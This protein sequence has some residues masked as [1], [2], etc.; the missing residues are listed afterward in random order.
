MHVC[1]WTVS[2]YPMV[3][4]WLRWILIGCGAAYALLFRVA[5]C[6]HVVHA[7]RVHARRAALVKVLIVQAVVRVHRISTYYVDVWCT[8]LTL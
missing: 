4:P 8:G 2:L 5:I 1:V 3:L 6:M 7:R